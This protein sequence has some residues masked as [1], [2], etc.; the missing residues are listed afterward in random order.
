MSRS[1]EITL[2]WADGTYPFALKWGQLEELQEKT[3]AGPYFLLGRLHD[4]SWRIGDIEH[5]IRLGLIGGG[6][7]P[8]AALALVRRYVQARPPLENLT[9]AQAILGAA[10]MGAPDET[11][12]KKDAGAEKPKRRSRAAK[13]ASPAS[14]EPEKPS[15]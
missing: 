2:D 9:T 8:M 13:S 15:D 10:V 14:T 5:T 11:V 12:G 6:M 7:A 4:G 3:D 1:A